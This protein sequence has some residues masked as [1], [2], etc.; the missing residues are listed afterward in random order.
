MNTNELL[1][2]EIIDKDGD[3]IGKVKGT[4]FDGKTWQITTLDVELDN[5]VA[6]DIGM[7]KRF[8]HTKLPLKS[9]FVSAIGD[10]IVLG[11]SKQELENYVSSL[12]QVETP[13]TAATT[14]S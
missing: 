11:S 1:E 8:G 6:E 2:K 5:K 10:R 3:T 9:S 13:K 12:K 7:K 14:T 4:N